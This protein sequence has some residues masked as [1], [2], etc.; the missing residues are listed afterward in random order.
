MGNEED[1]K[2]VLVEMLQSCT[3]A[4][5]KDNILQSFQ[6]E[7]GTIRV[8]IAT[9]AFGMVLNVKHIHIGPPKSIKAYVQK[10]GRAGR[11]GLPSMGYMLYKGI[12]LHHVHANM[13]VYVKFDTCQR[14]T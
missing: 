5:N 3:P 2:C 6:P 11:D 14:V 10:T 13:K 8:P 7:R 9:I 1:P 4:A 12:L